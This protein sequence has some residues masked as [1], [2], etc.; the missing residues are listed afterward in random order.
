MSSEAGYL[1]VYCPWNQRFFNFGIDTV[2]C[3]EFTIFEESSYII[4]INLLAL[5]VLSHFKSLLR[6]TKRSLSNGNFNFFY[7]QICGYGSQSEEE[8]PL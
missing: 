6:H 4:Q 1:R 5:P 7:K 2:Y 8:T 3:D